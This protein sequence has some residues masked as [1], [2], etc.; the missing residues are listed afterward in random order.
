MVK[1]K[2]TKSEILERGIDLASQL[3]LESLSIGN[4]AKE[5][6]MSKSG[7]FAHFNS[8]QNL[9]MDI[10]T[11]AGRQFSDEVVRP[12]LRVERGIPRIRAIVDNWINLSA[13]LGGGCIF[14][15]ASIEYSERPGK[16]RNLLLS[17]Q[18]EWLTS[19]KKIGASAVKAGDFREDS[20]CDQ[21]AYDLYSMMLGFHYYSRLLQDPKMHDHKQ[22]SLDQLIQIY[23]K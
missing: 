19:L 8:K 18:K 9:Q 1:G 17:Q 14:V 4:L 23:K 5:L 3:G 2:D 10:L 21:F 16:V 22:K 12:A 20:D 11:Q 6:N 15:T 13:K 7:L